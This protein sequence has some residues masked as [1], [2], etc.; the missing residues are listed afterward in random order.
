MSQWASATP[1]HRSSSRTSHDIHTASACHWK[2]LFAG[3]EHCDEPV[4]FRYAITPLQGRH[5]E[6]ATPMLKTILST[7]AF[8]SA[9]DPHVA[10]EAPLPASSCTRIHSTGSTASIAESK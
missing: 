10:G 4:G 3:P 9:C 8:A 7:I 6:G 5:Q 2:L 1:S